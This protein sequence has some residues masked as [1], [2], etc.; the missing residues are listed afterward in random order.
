MTEDE[1]CISLRDDGVFVWTS[2]TG[3]QWDSVEL[4]Q[5]A[6]KQNL[7]PADE[8]AVLDIVDKLRRLQRQRPKLYPFL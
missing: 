4:F 7:S 2:S 5:A 3:R 6:L 1:P 8:A